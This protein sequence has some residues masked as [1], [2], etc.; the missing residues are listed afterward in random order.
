MNKFLLGFLTLFITANGIGQEYKFGKVSKEELSQDVHA[1]EPDA[2]AAILYRQRHTVFNYDEDS[3][4]VLETE[5]IERIKIYN[6][7]GYE[8]ATVKIPMYVS[9]SSQEDVIA[10]K[11]Y[12]FNL[13]GGKIRE[14]KLQN[15]SIFKE[16]TSKT[17]KV[18]KFTMPDVSD[19]TIIEFKY[20]FLSPFISEVDE[21]V[22]QEQIPVDK[23]NMKMSI[24]DYLYYQTHGKGSIP[25]DV[26]KS[27]KNR[28]ISFIKTTKDFGGRT[29]GA[30]GNVAKERNYA[31]KESRERVQADIV[32][33]IY[34][35]NLTKVPSLKEEPFSTNQD[36]YKSKL[37]FELALTKFPNS[38]VKNYATTWEDVARTIY[39]SDQFGGELKLQKYYSKDLD[40]LIEGITSQEEKAF[41]IYK[42]VK[43]K[44]NWNN[45]YGVYTDEG[46]KKA[47]QEGVGNVADINL[48]LNSMLNYAGVEAS[49]ILISTKANG[50]SFFPTRSGFNYVIAGAKIEGK[51][52][53]MDGVDKEGV[54]NTLKPELLNWKGRMVKED[55]SSRLIELYPK[56]PAVHNSMLD[57]TIDENLD[58]LGNSKN[59]YSSHYAKSERDTYLNVSEED[60]LKKLNT[61][62]KSIDV[63]SHSLKDLKAVNKALSLEY[64]FEAEGAVEEIA[65]KLYISP[66]FHLATKTNYFKAEKRNSPI[67]FIYPWSDRY[68]VN[69]NIPAGYALESKPEDLAINLTEN[70]GS[71]RYNINQIGDMLTISLQNTIATPIIAPSYYKD[72]QAYFKMIVEKEAEKIVL[73]KI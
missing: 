58:V 46:V 54:I 27:T 68:I 15:K 6:Q 2:N 8:F 40:A 66:L 65:N 19:G 14:S 59:R 3:G 37:Q 49:P 55:G 21:F 42:F 16:E 53:L 60:Q 5:V 38:P 26:R 39:K 29:S 45:Y 69:I 13:V 62:Y 32:E 56:R 67:D 25:L 64:D 20:K 24:P 36:N 4:F 1:L 7:D 57:I 52:Y 22:F 43:D 51:L 12:S 71:Y 10:L 44:M 31:L 9:N 50:I 35:V 61:R 18:V 28:K 70:M 47:Y 63:V 33:N 34:E 11:A 30:T 48:M 23:V 41:A 73:K 72:L 17:S